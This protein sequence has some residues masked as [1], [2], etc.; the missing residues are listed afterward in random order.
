M[1]LKPT[2]ISLAV[3]SVFAG[4]VQAQTSP[5]I[6]ITPTGQRVTLEQYQTD[7][8]LKQIGIPSTWARGYTGLDVRIAVLDQGFDIRHADLKDRII[9]YQN[10]YSG[11]IS[12]TNAGWGYHGTAMASAAAGSLNGGVGTVG[13]AYN[14]GLLLGQVGQGGNMQ[15]IDSVAVIRGLNWAGQNGAVAV[16]MSFSSTFD[17]TY[18]SGTI[19]IAPG[20]YKGHASYG[21]MYGQGSALKQYISSTNLTSVIVAAAGNQGL[22]YSGYPG[23]FATATDSAG[24]LI[25][26]GRWLIVG[27]VDANNKISSFSN[28]AGSICTTL[29]SNVC[30]DKYYVKDFYVVAPGERIVVAQD[31]NSTAEYLA[32]FNSGT[33]A[34]TALVSG[35][36]AVIK[37]AWPQLKAAE[38][39]QL[40]KS[41]AT[42]LGAPGV[43]EVYGHG[44]VNFDKATQ[45]YADVKYSKVVLKSGT[46]A[47]GTT[48]TTTGITTSGPVGTSLMNS[49]VLKNVQVVDGLNR[50]YTADFTRAIGTST[51]ANSLYTSPYLAMQSADYR[52]FATS[53]GKDGVLTFMQSNTGFASQLETAYGEGKLSFQVGSMTEQNGFLNNTGSGLLATGGSQTAYAILGGSRP[54]ANNIDVIAQYGL[55]ITRTSNVDGSFLSLAPTLVSDTWK[56]GFAKKEVFFSGKTMV[57]FTLAVHGPVAIRKGYADVSAINSYT[58]SGEE[59]NVSATP[60]TATERV[61]LANGRRQ[62]DLI[63]GYSVSIGNTTY[64]GINIARQFNIGG[65]SGNNG[66]A[67]GLMVRTVF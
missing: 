11:S 23:A 67:L 43:D 40:V 48:L 10:F 28:R 41:T 25:F 8:A 45:P 53:V 51:P 13:A 30:Q 64:A 63:L 16:N 4:S 46:V 37:Q 62:T 29:V 9:S 58:Y 18:R 26:G 17:S 52:E 59:D 35:G 21:S 14:A 6:Y 20:V 24:N 5:Q 60:V 44:L 38:I 66:T 61:N 33:S 36:I 31:N 39:V 34:A 19:M 55:G 32:T 54:I 3:A 22:G 50:N 15:Q 65:A 2:I 42:D 49:G 1:K 56:V 47:G 12:A 57:Q 27:S 7:T